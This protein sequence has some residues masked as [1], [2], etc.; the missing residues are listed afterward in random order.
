MKCLSKEF[1]F[2]I[3]SVYYNVNTLFSIRDCGI[4][5]LVVNT[6]NYFSIVLFILRLPTF[7]Y[8]LSFDI[9]TKDEVV[10]YRFT[11][12]NIHSFVKDTYYEKFVTIIWSLRKYRVI[13]L[14][15]IASLKKCNIEL[16][17]INYIYMVYLLNV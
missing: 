17:I 2:I 5:L 10:I 1:N 12:Y 13:F 16:P 11:S 9:P 6:I 15:A 7:L 14:L 4:L 8:L 3:S